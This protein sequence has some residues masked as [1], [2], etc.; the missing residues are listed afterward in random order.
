MNAL[1]GDEVIVDEEFWKLDLFKEEEG[2]DEYKSEEGVLRMREKY[3]TLVKV[4][5]NNNE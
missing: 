3:F 2:D 1:V 5:G 4:K